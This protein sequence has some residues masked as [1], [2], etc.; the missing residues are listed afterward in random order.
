MRS[1]LHT[2]FARRHRDIHTTVRFFV[3]IWF[4]FI[5]V[6]GTLASITA[7]STYNVVPYVVTISTSN[8]HIP[9]LT[10]TADDMSDPGNTRISFQNGTSLWYSIS[11]TSTPTGIVPTAANPT[12]DIVT[13]TLL[14][15][16]SLLPPAQILPFDQWNGSYHVET[17]KLKTA[18]SGPG[19]QIQFQLVPTEQHAITLDIVTLL[20][21]LLGQ[22]Q[23]TIQV[24]LLEPGV[25]QDV[26]T[27]LGTIKDFTSL[28]GNY[29]QALTSTQDT[30]LP[31]AYAC[32]QDISALLSD[33][34]EQSALADVLWKVQG[35]AI[36]RDSILKTIVAFAQTQFGLAV[37]GFI[38]NEIGTMAGAFSQEGNPTIQMQTVSTITPSVTPSMSVSPSPSSSSSPSPSP[39]HF[40]VP[41][42]THSPMY[43]PLTPTA[44]LTH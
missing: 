27:E 34:S 1:I 16:P 5:L 35:K 2:L 14:G 22:K 23:S 10:L 41:S 9:L 21:Q 25:L 8:F 36:A 42:P 37:E 17:L 3:T 18:F 15:S 39:T 4:I 28:V 19:Q 43:T 12:S 6:I 31:H 44:T 11:T 24:G 26:F 38:N 13:T 7:H 29:G 30:A 32:A 20:L 40:P 33:S